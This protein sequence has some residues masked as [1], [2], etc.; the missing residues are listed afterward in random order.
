[1]N[2]A[3]SPFVS[4]SVEYLG[5]CPSLVWS[6]PLALGGAASICR[7]HLHRGRP[8]S[9]GC[10]RSFLEKRCEH[11][12]PT[13]HAIPAWANG[14]GTMRRESPKGQRPDSYP[15]DSIV[16]EVLRLGEGR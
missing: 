1:M 16:G 14:P 10:A 2:R 4:W 9:K 6:G 12:G 15:R 8:H 5:R 7:R 13:A 11:E 3:F